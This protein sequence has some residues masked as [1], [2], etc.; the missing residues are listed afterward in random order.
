MGEELELVEELVEDIAPIATEMPGNVVE[1]TKEAAVEVV[2]QTKTLLHLDQLKEYLNWPNLLK[3][4][5]S[6]IAILLFWAAYKA[7]VHFVKKG[8]SKKLE[9][10]T[11]KIITKGISYVFYVLI[12]MYILNLFGINLSAI[13][14]AA[15]IAGVAIGFAAQTSVSNL[16]SG[17]FVV[18]ERTMKIG[19]F[20]EISGV[21]GTVDSVGLLSVTI[22]TLD[23]QMIRI[24]NST[25]INSNL[26]NYSSFEKRRFV[27]PLPISYDSDMDT[28]LMAANEVADI[29][30]KNGVILSDPAPS[31]FYDGFGDAVN[32]RLAVWFERSKLIEAKNAIYTTAVKVFTKYGVVIPFTRYDI[33]ILSG[34]DEKKTAKKKA[35]P[36]QSIEK[37]A[38]PSLSFTE[39]A[40]KTV[41]TAEPKK[42]GRKPSKK[43]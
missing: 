5:T 8:A 28:A 36:I 4:L 19:D 10:H 32:L 21:S 14:G 13:W 23:N 37:I 11:V 27:F 2:N 38:K 39:T 31:A 20:I 34:N 7:I 15:G 18:I 6:V 25:V 43:D 9:A 16:I 24:P 40:T 29:C 17:I 33:N 41:A 26:I 22:H 30:I 3:V 35:E 42:R 12:I 1:A